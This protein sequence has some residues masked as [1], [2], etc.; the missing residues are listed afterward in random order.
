MHLNGKLTVSEDWADFGGLTISLNGLKSELDSI[1]ASA[2]ERKQAY[3]YFFI[4]YGVSWRTLVR[5][6]KMLY[7]MLISVHS[8]A[9]DRVNR[10]VPQ[11]QEWVDAFDIKETDA[12]FIPANKRLKFF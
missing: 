5:K 8:P 2:T 11:F 1:N 6:K 9:E 7:A 4:S 10:I 3:R 12:L